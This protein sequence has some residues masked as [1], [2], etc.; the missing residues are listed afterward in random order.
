MSRDLTSEEV[1]TIIRQCGES[2][3]SVLKFGAL[4]VAF[5]DQVKPPEYTPPLFSH[6][7]AEI[8]ENPAA[9]Q[10]EQEAIHAD[11]LQ[12]KLDRLA[13]MMVEDP[14]QYEKLLI[15]GDLENVEAE[16]RGSQ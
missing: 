8:S 3:V 12:V 2:H 14:A 13:M 16:D 11:E 15:D 1:C 10:I 5:H 4:E 9:N 6:P 7:E